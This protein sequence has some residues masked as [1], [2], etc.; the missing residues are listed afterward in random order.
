MSEDT[1]KLPPFTNSEAVDAIALVMPPE[2]ARSARAQC[3]H[4]PDTPCMFWISD[5]MLLVLAAM[6]DDLARRVA[7]FR[8]DLAP[9][10]EEVREDPAGYIEKVR[11]EAH[12]DGGLP[13]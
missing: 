8:P 7:G 2:V 12:G 13:T 5:G 10:V 9:K 11:G 3:G 1:R 4:F 6:S